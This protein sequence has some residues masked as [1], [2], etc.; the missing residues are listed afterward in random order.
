MPN[1]LRIVASDTAKWI[2]LLIFMVVVCNAASPAAFAQSPS[3]VIHLDCKGNF[4]RTSGDWKLVIDL[5][6]KAMD[7]GGGFSYS[8]QTMRAADG[9][10]LGQF[11]FSVTDEAY[12]M[13]ET[14]WEGRSAMLVTIN[15]STGH[16]S[17]HAWNTNTGD[18]LYD[19]SSECQ[20][21]TV[22]PPA[23]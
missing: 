15:R 9:S 5:D 6:R 10:L 4:M 3:R 16:L 14:D 1:H 23:F 22:P 13:T 21:I 17:Y 20:V 8:E 19:Q 2:V 7:F 12:T 11:T 18:V